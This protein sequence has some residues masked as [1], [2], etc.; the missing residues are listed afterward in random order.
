VTATSSDEIAPVGL[1]RCVALT[2][3]H[4]GHGV[5]TAA[6]YLARALVEQGLR[7]LLADLS[8]HQSPL[9][10][11]AAHDPVRN[12][13]PWAPA[14]VP[15]TQL[16]RVL[17]SVRQNTAGRADV[18]L[19]DIDAT[20]LTTAGGLEAGVDYVLLVAENSPEGR[21]GAERLAARLHG[22]RAARDRIGVVFSRVEAPAVEGL[23]GR[24]EN[25]LPVL[26]WLPADYLLAAG[27][28]YS[29]KG[30]APARPH[31]VYTNALKRLAQ[32]LIRLVPLQRH[33][34]SQD[35]TA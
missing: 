3:G 30:S 14:L 11:L 20:L 21:S 25:G 24:L 33:R 15:P 10:A 23:S 16:P 8:Q 17:Q 6:Y 9:A 34:A 29:L 32:T 2:Q 7:V 26:G 31:E 22:N 5:S 4:R 35:R 1:P 13:V 19:L 12:L 28:A 27:E 18:L